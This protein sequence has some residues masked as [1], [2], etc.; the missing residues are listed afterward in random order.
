MNDTKRTASSAEE[1]RTSLAVGMGF[2][3]AS[4]L[5][6]A[7]PVSIARSWPVGAL[8]AGAAGAEVSADGWL[9]IA[10]GMAALA[11]GTAP[12]PISFVALDA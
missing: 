10:P 5:L 9:G 4:A 3:C 11:W 2:F 6:V 8:F 7:P 12:L 1:W